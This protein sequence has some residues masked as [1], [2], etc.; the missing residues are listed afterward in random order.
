MFIE[1]DADTLKQWNSL[2]LEQRKHAL[3][4]DEVQMA[5]DIDIKIERNQKL[6]EEHKYYQVITYGKCKLISD[7]LVSKITENEIIF[8]INTSEEN[9]E[10][11]SISIKLNEEKIIEIGNVPYS[12]IYRINVSN[13]AYGQAVEL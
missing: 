9:K 11:D 7:I 1:F 10:Y 8:S 13:P 12:R 4:N 3:L 6:I 5:V 2:S